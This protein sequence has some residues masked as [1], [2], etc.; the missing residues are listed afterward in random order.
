MT[1]RALPP[2]LIIALSCLS[3][4]ALLALYA[5]AQLGLLDASPGPWFPF[6]VVAVRYVVPNALVVAGLAFAALARRTHRENRKLYLATIVCSVAPLVTTMLI[7]GF[8][9]LRGLAGL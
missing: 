3:V 6:A 2:A 1:S 8:A 7:F 5:V 9:L 4:A